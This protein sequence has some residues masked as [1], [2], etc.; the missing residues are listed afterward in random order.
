MNS[1]I[2]KYQLKDL[3]HQS[4]PLH[5]INLKLYRANLCI[6]VFIDLS[7]MPFERPLIYLIACR[8]NVRLRQSDS[9]NACKH[10]KSILSCRLIPVLST[11]INVSVH[12]TKGQVMELEVQRNFSH[13][14]K[15]IPKHRK[16]RGNPKNVLF[17]KLFWCDKGPTSRVISKI[18]SLVCLLF[19]GN[20]EFNLILLG[21]EGGVD[22]TREGDRVSWNWYSARTTAAV[23]ARRR[24]CQHG[25]GQKH[26]LSFFS[27]R[28]FFFCTQRRLDKTLNYASC[29][30]FCAAS[31][32]L[33]SW[34]PF[35]IRK[36]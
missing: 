3:L 32:A 12:S 20:N 14:V 7:S 25:S 19:M 2:V 18:S 21:C 31:L 29:C 35:S 9:Q 6:Q 8:P 30:S 34:L 11:E 17:F 33:V 13:F 10:F 4:S 36:I 15:E 5:R 16:P 26:C 24:R 28:K 22:K 1:W 23:D 27:G